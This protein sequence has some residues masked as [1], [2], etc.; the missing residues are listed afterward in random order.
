MPSRW[1]RFSLAAG[2]VLSTGWSVAGGTGVDVRVARDGLFFFAA[3]ALVALAWGKEFRDLGWTINRRAVRNTLVLSAFVLPF[4]LVGSSLP[5]IRS[6]YPMWETAPTLASFLPHAAKQLAIVLAAETFYRGML[7]VG[8]REI[9]FKSVFISPVL[10]AI[11]HTAK[12]PIELLLSGPTDVLFGAVDYDCRSI[13]PSVVAH[14]FG[15]TLLDWLVLH[16]PMLPP[17]QLVR[18]LRWLP[19]VS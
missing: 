15:I 19:V 12:P 6:Y 2:L 14:G 18:W 13:L 10:Y 16:D 3:P 11:H 8:V 4:Y 9:G 7:C 1:V 5:S 17:E